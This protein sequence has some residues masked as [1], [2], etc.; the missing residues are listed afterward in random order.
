MHSINPVC[1]HKF[2]PKN[3]YFGKNN[4]MPQFKVSKLLHKSERDFGTRECKKS[5][6]K[7]RGVTRQFH[8]IS[9]NFHANWEIPGIAWN[10]SISLLLWEK[11]PAE[12]QCICQ[13]GIIAMMPWQKGF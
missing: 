10:F 9:M 2:E 8:V 3:I 5:M 12:I 11:E 7:I 1:Q 13:V 6:E 4:I